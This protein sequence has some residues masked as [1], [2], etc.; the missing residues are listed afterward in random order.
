MYCFFLHPVWSKYVC[1]CLVSEKM[2]QNKLD[3]IVKQ[4]AYTTNIMG[5]VSFSVC[6]M[7]ITFSL[8]VV[9]LYPYTFIDFASWPTTLLLVTCYCKYQAIPF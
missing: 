7:F 6:P 5:Q 9:S 2:G 4:M 3:N 1:M 8:K